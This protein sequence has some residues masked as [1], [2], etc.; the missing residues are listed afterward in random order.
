M[1]VI[2]DLFSRKIV[3]WEVWE[4]ESA[5]YASGLIQRAILS[6]NLTNREEPLILHSDNGSP[7]RGTTIL[8]TLYNLGITPSRS[9]P[10]VSNDNAYVESLFRT[11][12]YRCNYQPKGFESIE[13]AREWVLNFVEWY[14]DNH[15]HSGIKFLTP[16]QR[17][18]EGLGHEVLRRRNMVYKTAKLNNPGRW[19][20]ETRDW[21]I[22][23]EVWLNPA[24][25]ITESSK[26][27]EAS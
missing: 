27:S 22:D 23:D 19:T 10:R 25:V 15:R 2:S 7:M 5:K 17:H 13:L 11:L 14:N 1:Y 4:K 24:K 20:R 16:N 12:K 8:E 21:S 26:S 6:E 3:A 18:S 9:R